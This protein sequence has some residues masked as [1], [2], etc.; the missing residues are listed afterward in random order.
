MVTITVSAYQTIGSQH[1][2]IGVIGIDVL[3]SQFTKYASNLTYIKNLLKNQGHPFVNT[4]TDCQM[5]NIRKY[6]CKSLNC[7]TSTS[8]TCST[9]INGSNIFKNAV[10][11]SLK[12][13]CDIA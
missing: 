6:K 11:T 2:L 7:S 4:A 3:V 9:Q 13:N 5:Q 1:Q 8:F 10:D 12:Q